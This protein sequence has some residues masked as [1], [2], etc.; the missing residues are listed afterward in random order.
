MRENLSNEEFKTYCYSLAKSLNYKIDK[1][2]P[3]RLTTYIMGT[4]VR[5][6]ASRP[7]YYRLKNLLT[8]HNAPKKIQK[9]SVL[10][11]IKRP[12]NFLV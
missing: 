2:L 4:S 3:V 9:F 5:A 12:F 1:D 6:A 7:F 8:I 11:E 10:Y